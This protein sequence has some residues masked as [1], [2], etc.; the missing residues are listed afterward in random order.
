LVGCLVVCLFVSLSFWLVGCADGGR[1]A[2]GASANNSS[3]NRDN[4]VVN[5]ALNQ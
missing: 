2:G 5:A 4:A 1:G 3:A